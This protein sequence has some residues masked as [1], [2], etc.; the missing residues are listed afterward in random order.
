[1]K[2]KQMARQFAKRTGRTIKDCDLIIKDFISFMMDAIID[3]ERLEMPG[4]GALYV[5]IN[6]GH[7]FRDLKGVERMTRDTYTTKF[8]TYPSFKE[9][10]QKIMDQKN[11]KNGGDASE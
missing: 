11:G 5:S 3:G 6:H 8:T 10:L 9:A 7:K 1:M 4:F 2:V